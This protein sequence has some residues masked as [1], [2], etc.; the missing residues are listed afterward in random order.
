MDTIQNAQTYYRT[1]RWLLAGLIIISF[2]GFRLSYF[3]L[4][5][6]FKGTSWVVHFHVI[7]V[8]MWYTLLITQA[9]WAKQGRFFLHKKYGKLSYI[10]VPIIL[11]GIVLMTHHGQMKN[12][13]PDLL[14][15]TMFDSLM[16]I[17]FYIL[18]LKH[19]RNIHYHADYMIL[20]AVPFINPGLGRFIGP[21]ISLPVEFLLLLGMFFM[22]SKHGKPQKPY[23]VAILTFLTLLAGIV[24]ISIIQPTIIES[25]WNFI[26]G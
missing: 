18:A 23:V 4:F 19:R 6:T 22:A 26:W 14:G 16:F 2:L 8:L 10:L 21:E 11:S 20:T 25:M 17:T 3:G 24:F 9:V 15:A 12:K 5:P 7:T 1:M 13:A